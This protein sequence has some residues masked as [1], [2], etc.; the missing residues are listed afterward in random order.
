MKKL[1]ILLAVLGLIGCGINDNTSGS[2]GNTTSSV[3]ETFLSE[4]DLFKLIS[5]KVEEEYNLNEDISFSETLHADEHSFI[6]FWFTDKDDVLYEG[7]AY[8]ITDGEDWRIEQYETWKVNKNFSFTN[9]SLIAP[10]GD[11]TN[12]DFKVISGYINDSNISQIRVTNRNSTMKVLSV[13]GRKTYMDYLIGNIEY[14][15]SIV[16]VDKKGNVI[17]EYRWD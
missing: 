3:E 10:L 17:Y 13:D 6:K 7:V 1:F 2:E 16:A 5:S 12:R 15:K 14:L 9:H 4:T 11:G 8:S